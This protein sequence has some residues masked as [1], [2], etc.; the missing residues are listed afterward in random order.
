MTDKAISSLRRRLI[1]DMAMG[2]LTPKTQYQYI[3]Q[4]RRSVLPR[5]LWPSASL[6]PR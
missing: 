2:R 3:R 4:W 6:A 1:E 5:A